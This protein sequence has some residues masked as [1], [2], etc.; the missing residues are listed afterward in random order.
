MKEVI[1]MGKGNLDIRKNIQAGNDVQSLA[2]SYM[3]YFMNIACTMFEW[4]N[5]GDYFDERFAEAALFWNGWVTVCYDSALESFVCGNT[6]ASGSEITGVGLDMYGNYTSSEINAINNYRRV[7]TAKNSVIIY[8]DMARSSLT[9]AASQPYPPARYLDP[10][11]N[12][13][14]YTQETK[15]VNLTS[16]GMPIIIKGSDKQRLTM[17]Q[18]L[19]SFLFRERFIMVDK[20]Q[21]TN[22]DIEALNT[23]VQCWLQNLDDSFER[24][25]NKGLTYL[26]VD[27]AVTSKRERLIVDEV[28][29]NNQEVSTMALSKLIARNGAL[30][31]I[32]RIYGSNC[33]VTLRE[34]QM[35]IGTEGYSSAASQDDEDEFTHNEPKSSGGEE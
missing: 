29:A 18:K 17:M 26:G 1:T 21:Y 30:E 13:M 3:N 16:M 10:I 2:D 27:N 31:K 28:N 11:V 33:Y 15:M 4:H 12:E 19:R 24:A 9:S 35:N 34:S 5:M 14:A 6:I 7:L 25:R 20:E 22:D 8:N 23:G 32:N